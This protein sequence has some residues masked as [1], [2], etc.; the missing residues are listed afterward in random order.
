[1]IGKL[2]ATAGAVMLLLAAVSTDSTAGS[3]ARAQDVP[4]ILFERGRVGQLDIYATDPDGRRKVRV[5]GGATDDIAPAWAPSGDRFAF[6]SS[7]DGSWQV[8][9]MVLGAQ[10]PVQLTKGPASNTDAA[11]SPDGSQIAFESNRDG[12]WSVF[13]MDANGHNERPLTEGPRDEYDPAWRP[14]GKG[15]VFDRVTRSGSDLYERD[16]R[17]RA[18]RQLTDTTAAEFDPAYDG[19]GTRLAFDRLRGRDYDVLVLD[20]KSGKITPV[21]D[22]RASEFQ[23]RWSADG[24]FIL[25]TASVRD[26]FDLYRAPARGSVKRANITRSTR[27]NDS[28]ASWRPGVASGVTSAATAAADPPAPN[29]DCS[30]Y[31]N[32]GFHHPY[33]VRKG[34]NGADGLC[35]SHSIKRHELRAYRGDDYL[36]GRGGADLLRAGAG[37]DVLISIDGW[38]DIL[39]G[40]TGTNVAWVDKHKDKN[41]TE[42]E[43]VYK[44]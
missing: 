26:Q 28:G 44:P 37:D 35:G 34:S 19:P 8:Y 36:D 27:S 1:M 4:P 39:R 5:V 18:E 23:P 11:W 32:G 42:L 17:T 3:R 25:Y 20:L 16:V 29:F 40:G 2:S 31:T 13:V 14:D 43:T 10:T 41:R 22:T 33:W 12:D 30:S 38:N 7:R 21:A 15:V 24:D 9:V 6:T